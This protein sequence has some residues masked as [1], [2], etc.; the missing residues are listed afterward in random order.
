MVG[1]KRI[2]FGP[3]EKIGAGG[4]K[5]ITLCPVNVNFF[6]VLT[7]RENPAFQRC[8]RVIQELF[9]NHRQN[10][11]VHQGG[12]KFVFNDGIGQD[13]VCHRSNVCSGC[14]GDIV[15]VIG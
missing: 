15:L 11:F 14:D 3:S 10:H 6:N 8:Q 2:G 1:D 9:V 7:Q 13:R 12:D 5:S 4:I